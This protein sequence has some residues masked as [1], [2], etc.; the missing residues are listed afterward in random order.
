VYIHV[1]SSGCVEDGGKGLYSSQLQEPS[2]AVGCQ[3]L[4]T[5]Q[6][7]AHV[8]GHWQLCCCLRHGLPCC[9]TA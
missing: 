9:C 2:T 5:R 6:L 7:Q 1:H 4:C 8:Q 3:E